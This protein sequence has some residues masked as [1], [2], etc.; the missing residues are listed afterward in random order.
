MLERRP[1]VEFGFFKTHHCLL[2]CWSFGT[3][4]AVS[5][6][7]GKVLQGSEEAHRLAQMRRF[8]LARPCHLGYRSLSQLLGMKCHWL[9]SPFEI[10]LG[11]SFCNRQPSIKAKPWPDAA[12][13]DRQS[14][15]HAKWKINIKHDK[16][17][18]SAKCSW[19]EII[20]RLQQFWGSKPIVDPLLPNC[21][22]VI[23]L[24]P[25]HKKPKSKAQNPIF[26][27]CASSWRVWILDCWFW[28]SDFRCTERTWML[29]TKLSAHVWA[30]FVSL[31]GQTCNWE[32]FRIPG[33]K[34]WTKIADDNGVAIEQCFYI[35]RADY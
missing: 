10:F 16:P 13:W 20:N 17:N 9:D 31:I 7:A 35:F 32:T 6:Q 8:V 33:Q 28:I 27:L 34:S 3:A 29:P 12:R 19:R 14:Q 5:D 18:V 21:L 11:F 30:Y 4:A 25:P 24:A 2:K 22:V 15:H 1:V 26:S 23:L